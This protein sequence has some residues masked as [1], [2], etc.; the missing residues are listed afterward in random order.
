MAATLNNWLGWDIPWATRASDS[1]DVRWKKN[2]YEAAGLAG[3][4]ELLGAAFAFGRKTKLLARDEAAQAAIDSRAAVSNQYDNPLTEVIEEGRAAKE[5]AEAK[6]AAD[7]AFSEA[8]A[9]AELA[10]NFAN[11]FEAYCKR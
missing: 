8:R 2:V 9:L 3:G 5:A 1:P 11:N 7:A 10:A 6:V 4:V